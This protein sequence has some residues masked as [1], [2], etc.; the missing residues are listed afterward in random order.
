MNY[1][2]FNFSDNKCS[3]IHSRYTYEPTA[4]GKGW[5]SKPTEAKSKTVTPQ[6]YTNFVNSIPFFNRLGTCRAQRH[7]TAVGYLPTVI[8]SISPNREIKH[9]DVFLFRYEG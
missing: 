9:V 3:I 1:Q 2:L 7:Y 4:S 5:K 6:F 8:T